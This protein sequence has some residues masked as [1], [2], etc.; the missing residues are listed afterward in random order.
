MPRS[1]VMTLR[2]WTFVEGEIMP[3]KEHYT[4]VSDNIRRNVLRGDPTGLAVYLEI[5]SRI[6]DHDT[7]WASAQTIA[8]SLGLGIATVKRAIKRL[9]ELHL[10]QNDKKVGRVQYISLSN[11]YQNDTIKYQNDTIKYQ[12]DTGI[13]IKMIRNRYQND[14]L[15]ILKKDTNLSRGNENKKSSK[16]ISVHDYS[17]SPRLVQWAKKTYPNLDIKNTFYSFQS[18]NSGR[19][20]Y[21]AWEMMFTGYVKK[22]AIYAKIPMRKAI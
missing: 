22:M 8:D 15:S 20:S 18:W 11:R 7:M 2:G 3:S 9:K 5:K 19:A 21:Q 12:N 14:T 17:P 6:G 16:K 13:G 10:I 1:E 4:T